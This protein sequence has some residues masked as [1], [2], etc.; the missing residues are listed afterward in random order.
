[1]YFDQVLV[2]FGICWMYLNYGFIVLVES[3]QWELGIEFGCYLIEVVCEFLGMVIIWLDGGFVVVGFGVILMV[4]DLVVF[5]GDLL[6]LLMVLVQM[7]VDV[8]MVQFFGLDGVLFGYGVQW[9]ND[10]GLGFEIRNLKL[11]YWIG[12]CN[13]MWIFG[14]FG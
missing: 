2:C 4:V 10:W 6:C 5:V 12:E 13:L 7:Y 14:Y 3:V 9:F 1:M 11:F 8:I